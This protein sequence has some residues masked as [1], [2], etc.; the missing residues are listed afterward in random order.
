MLGEVTLLD[1]TG[2]DPCLLETIFLG[3]NATP[4]DLR[5]AGLALCNL[6]VFWFLH[7]NERHLFLTPS[8]R[9]N[10]IGRNVISNELL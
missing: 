9:E 4:L 7:L 3:L 10:A 8:V 2:V 6:S 1:A 5:E